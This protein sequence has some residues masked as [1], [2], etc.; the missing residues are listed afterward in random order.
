MEV[1]NV[2]TP[3]TMVLDVRSLGRRRASA[4]VRLGVWDHERDLGPVSAESPRCHRCNARHWGAWRCV[5]NRVRRQSPRACAMYRVPFLN[6]RVC[7]TRTRTPTGSWRDVA[8]IGEK[9]RSSRASV[10][11]R[12]RHPIRERWPFQPGQT[13]PR[14]A[15]PA[16]TAVSV[17]EGFRLLHGR[18]RPVSTWLNGD[19]V[20][21]LAVATI[22]NDRKPVRRSNVQRSN[23]GRLSSGY[24]SMTA[25]PAI[26]H[27]LTGPRCGCCSWQGSRVQ[28]RRLS[29]RHRVLQLG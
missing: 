10:V 21:T 19:N 5:G 24:T 15:C 13:S 9:P 26:L 18:L 16:P 28:L 25:H 3:N 4:R 17:V 27:S 1:P 11:P 8:A 20:Q 12:T 14:C 7:R 6:Q 22:R 2:K 23:L 29:K